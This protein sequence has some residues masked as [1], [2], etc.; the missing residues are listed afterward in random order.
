LERISEKTG[1]MKLAWEKT[2]LSVNFQLK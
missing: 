2:Q 1:V